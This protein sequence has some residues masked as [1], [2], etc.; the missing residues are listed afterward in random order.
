M[1][2]ADGDPPTEADVL[3]RERDEAVAHARAMEHELGRVRGQLRRLEL[4]VYRRTQRRRLARSYLARMSA[5]VR[6]ARP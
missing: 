3:R 2:R 4:V 5:M 6:R 1:S